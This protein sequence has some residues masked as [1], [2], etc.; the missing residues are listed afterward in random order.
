MW[1]FGLP[2]GTS[3]THI[4]R[5][6][7]PDWFEGFFCG[8]AP[9]IFWPLTLLFFCRWPWKVGAERRAEIDARERRIAELEKELNLR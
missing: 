9:A 5:D 7:E 1:R 4:L 6:G 8:I 3:P 2:W